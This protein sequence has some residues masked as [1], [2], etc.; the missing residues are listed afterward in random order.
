MFWKICNCFKDNVFGPKNFGP[1]KIL[2]W[3]KTVGLKP[4]NKSDPETENFVNFDRLI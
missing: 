1:P 4:T 3:I 2:V